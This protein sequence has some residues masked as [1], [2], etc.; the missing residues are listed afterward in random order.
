LA[1]LAGDVQ[2]TAVSVNTSMPH[3]KSGKVK[4]L[5]IA[6]LKRS[7]ALPEVRTLA[8]QGV[9]GAEADSWLAIFGPPGVPEPIVA[10]LQHEIATALNDPLIKERL[11]GIGLTVVASTPAQLQAMLPGEVSK[12]GD[13]VRRSGAKVD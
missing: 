5:A 9:T 11:A 12:W 2:L 13:A 4:A 6:S 10:K 3:I 1:V 8:E 7:P